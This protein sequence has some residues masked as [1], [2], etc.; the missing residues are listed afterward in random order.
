MCERESGGSVCMCVLGGIWELSKPSSQFFCNA[1]AALKKSVK[2]RKVPVIPPQHFYTLRY[3][4][5]TLFFSV[6]MCN[7]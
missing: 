1:N 5:P 4:L 2:K 7:T 6:S 3:I